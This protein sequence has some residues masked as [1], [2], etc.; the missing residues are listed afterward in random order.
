MNSALRLLPRKLSK[1]KLQNSRLHF[2]TRTQD[3]YILIFHWSTS[4]VFK[5]TFCKKNKWLLELI[6]DGYFV[7][8]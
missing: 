7:L 5:M 2:V 3:G 8:I 1:L 4:V 6:Y